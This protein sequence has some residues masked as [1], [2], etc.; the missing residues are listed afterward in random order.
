MHLVEGVYFSATHSIIFLMS[1]IFYDFFSR[2]SNNPSAAECIHS[3][4]WKPTGVLVDIRVQ[5]YSLKWSWTNFKF[6]FLH[7]AMFQIY[8]FPKWKYWLEPLLWVHTQRSYS[9]KLTDCEV[10]KITERICTEG[11]SD[12]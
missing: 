4:G 9:G 11:Y 8:I 10:K 5:D 12:R 7:C 6:C 2:V 3:M 1:V